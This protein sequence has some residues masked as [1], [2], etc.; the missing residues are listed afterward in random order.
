[1]L[2]RISPFECFQLEWPHKKIWH[3]IWRVKVKQ[4][5]FVFKHQGSWGRH[6]CLTRVACLLAHL[7][8]VKQQPGHTCSAL[9]C[10]LFWLLLPLSRDMFTSM[11]KGTCISWRTPISSRLEAVRTEMSPSLWITACV[12]R[13]HYVL[14]VL[15]FLLSCLPCGLQTTSSFTKTT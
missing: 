5:P 7:V 2:P 14:A 8:G 4:Q 6:F 3:E 15:S 12:P 11:T 13:C 1:M 9:P 10:V